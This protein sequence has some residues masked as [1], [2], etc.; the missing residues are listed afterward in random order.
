MFLFAVTFALATDYAVL[1]MARIKELRDDG[2]SNEDAVAQGVARTGRII[3]AAAVMI[4]V[5]FAA[6]AVSPVFFMK[7]IAIGMAL[8]VI[9]DATIVR[10]LLVPSLMRLLGERELVGAAIPPAVARPDRDQGR[11]SRHSPA[12]HA[13]SA[14]RINRWVR[15]N[16]ASCA[17]TRLCTC[18][19]RHRSDAQVARFVPWSAK[20][21]TTS[22]TVRPRSWSRRA[23]RT[24]S[25]SRS[26]K[27]R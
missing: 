2:L 7:Q 3:S 5:V 17:S 22:S 26:S 16:S 14:S 25:R 8:G 6:F 13:S 9:I 24:R 4:A 27:V 19:R 12:S 10:A 21:A 11:L 15:R 23:S 18:S 20:A 1:V